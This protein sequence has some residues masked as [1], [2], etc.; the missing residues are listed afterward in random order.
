MGFGRIGRNLFRLLY[1][2]EDIRLVA[3]S[4]VADHA[5]L[6]Y[7]LRY[8]TLLGRFP[9]PVSLKEDHLYAAGRRFKMLSGADPGDVDWDAL[10]VDTVIEA[11]ARYQSSD[12]LR[13]HLAAGAKRVV[14]CAPPTDEPDITVVMGVNDDAL[15]PSHRIIS[16]ASG[17]V[18][19]AAPIIKILMR[20]F[21]I[22][23]LF[24]DTVH[25]YTNAQRLADVPADELRM[26]RAA[27]ENI[28]PTHTNAGEMLM[29]LFPE[30]GGKVSSLAMNVPVPNGSLVDM[31][32]FTREAVDVTAVN[33]VVRT[34]VQADYQRYVEYGTDPIVS[35][36]VQANPHSSIFDSLATAT[37]GDNV[38]KCIAWYD[39]GWGYAHRA[40]ELVE[41]LASLEEEAA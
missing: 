14:L 18:H 11:T 33:E 36:D 26:S 17:T 22:E 5:G 23:A 40:L 41:R 4:D 7:L 6:E 13:A 38:V 27:I 25:A 1:R 10:G 39:N 8:D 31:V 19:C 32:V 16:N 21:G 37:L 20:A 15:D 9:D 24:I 12:Y 28:I 29:K 35:S 34:A 30:L 2:R 3:I